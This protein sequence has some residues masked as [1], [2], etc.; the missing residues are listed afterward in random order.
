M[1][2]IIGHEEVEDLRV[3][4]QVVL[5]GCG[6]SSGNTCSAV[7]LHPMIRDVMLAIYRCRDKGVY[8]HL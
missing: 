3:T 8:I 6:V 7:G 2:L 4:G 1:T 5:V